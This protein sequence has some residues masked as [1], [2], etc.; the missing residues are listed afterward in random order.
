[1]ARRH[2]KTPL[3]L[4]D[5][6]RRVLI[7]ATD[8]DPRIRA[9]VE[10]VIGKAWAGLT[11]DEKI[12]ALQQ[13]EEEGFALRSL[14]ASVEG[15]RAFERVVDE[16]DNEISLADRVA[17]LEEQVTAKSETIERQAREIKRLKDQ[18]TRERRSRVAAAAES[19]RAVNSGEPETAA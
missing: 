7:G 8:R 4:T 9:G 10:K 1:M 19:A 6:N 3:V 12:G 11:D 2:S 5:V 13:T 16:L 17:L 15:R 14:A 18:A